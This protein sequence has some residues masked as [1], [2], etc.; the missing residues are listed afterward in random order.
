[1]KVPT[2]TTAGVGFIPMVLAE[3]MRD[4]LSIQY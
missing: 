4:E 3:I 1:M 2:Y